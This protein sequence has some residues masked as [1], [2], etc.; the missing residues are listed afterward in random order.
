MCVRVC[1]GEAAG[2]RGGEAA[3][4]R[5]YR[6]CVRGEGW[7]EGRGLVREARQRAHDLRGCQ[8]ADVRVRLQ[9]PVCRHRHVG[10]AHRR[11]RARHD[12]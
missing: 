10:R 2:R 4:L 11:A 6:V 8:H 12:A 3:G 5:R 9:E 1:S 7:G